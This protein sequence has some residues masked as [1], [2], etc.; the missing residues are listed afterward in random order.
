MSRK[1]F[2]AVL[3]AACCALAG[4][5]KD[6]EVESVVTELHA[7]SEE[8]VTKVQSA[9][10]PSAGVDEAQ[11]LMDSRK[12]EL[13]TKVAL[14]KDVKGFQVSQET[15]RRI[16][17]TLARDAVSVAGLRIKYLG[18]SAKDPAFRAKLDRLVNDYAQVLQAG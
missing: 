9:P 15:R 14:I 17:D 4:C 2:I 11:K 5:G 10:N 12:A 1:S 16:T 13:R 8:L 18:A 3:L 7:F 6:A